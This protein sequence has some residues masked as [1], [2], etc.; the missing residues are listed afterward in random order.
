MLP[1]NYQ[2]PK[3]G[4]EDYITLAQIYSGD[5]REDVLRRAREVTDAECF[6]HVEA[7]LE[8]Y[9]QGHSYLAVPV[10][11]GKEIL[12]LKRQLTEHEI[13]ALDLKAQIRHAQVQGITI[14]IQGLED[15]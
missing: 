10:R 14:N 11:H 7:G 9:V 3:M 13:K 5:S 8:F 6:V 15:I 4:L 1:F 2:I 12:H